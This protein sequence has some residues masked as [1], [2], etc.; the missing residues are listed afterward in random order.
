MDRNFSISYQNSLMSYFC[1]KSDFIQNVLKVAKVCF[2]DF[3]MKFCK[4]KLSKS[5]QSGNTASSFLP[6]EFNYVHFETPFV[7]LKK[8]HHKIFSLTTWGMFRRS[9]SMSDF[10]ISCDFIWKRIKLNTE[11]TLRLKLTFSHVKSC[12]R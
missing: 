6:R 10:R 3:C 8:A 2:G 1:I 11:I 7:H 5:A 9:I 4:Q 12:Q